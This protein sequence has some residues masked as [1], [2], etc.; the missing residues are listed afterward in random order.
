MRQNF[1]CMCPHG[2]SNCTDAAA[3]RQRSRAHGDAYL[4]K[5]SRDAPRT[6]LDTVTVYLREEGKRSVRE[7]VGGYRLINNPSKHCIRNNI[8]KEIVAK[9]VQS[10]R[11]ADS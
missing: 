8:N 1:M 7:Y 11:V 6:F 5:Y 10:H 4:R 2:A 3:C 9:F